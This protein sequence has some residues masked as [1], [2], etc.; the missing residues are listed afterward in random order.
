MAESAGKRTENITEVEKK[1]EDEKHQQNEGAEEEEGERRIEK[2]KEK[3]TKKTTEKSATPGATP[4][5]C[6]TCGIPLK[7]HKWPW[8][9]KCKQ[10]DLIQLDEGD[11]EE[12]EGAGEDEEEDES[13]GSSEA[14]TPDESSDPSSEEEMKKTK[15]KGKK[16]KTKK[17][18][19]R[20]KKK[21]KKREK[22]TSTPYKGNKTEG[23]VPALS[24]VAGNLD[25]TIV[26]IITE[27]LDKLG[28]KI[29][30]VD[31]KI[32]DDRA[33]RSRQS[34]RQYTN[35]EISYQVRDDIQC[36]NEVSDA[37][38]DLLDLGI[39]LKDTGVQHQRPLPGLRPVSDTSDVRH[40]R[41]HPG[42][43][44]ASI[45]KILSGEYC[46]L[47]SMLPAEIETLK[48]D[49]YETYIENGQLKC[50]IK[51]QKRDINSIICWI[52]AWAHYERIMGEY[53]GWPALKFLHEYKLRVLKWYKKY[54]WS[55]IYKWDVELRK[56][57]SL[58]SID[59]VSHDAALFAHHFDQTTYKPKKK[60]KCNYCNEETHKGPCNPFRGGPG[61]GTSTGQSRQTIGQYRYSAARPDSCYF[62]NNSQCLNQYCNRP[63]C[64][65]SC[66]GPMPSY[67]CRSSGRCSYTWYK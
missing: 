24:F 28:N 19:K 67:E 3:K 7:N 9:K 35:N 46:E 29:E 6:R 43:S 60:E 21:E 65:K 16:K 47:S 64:C 20:E 59:F 14:A 45:R 2:K 30:E 50:K 63:H 5:K 25:R 53:H 51:E 42:I 18:G 61:T 10:L 31:K 12:D 62:F 66:G 34:E 44:E 49:E 36:L 40:L 26:D 55:S 1:E 27:K 56:E 41:H 54:S 8:G 33:E 32:E 23:A 58:K 39:V 48:E 4:K 15:K 17:P 22:E 37:Q 11:S 52:E 38:Q 13:S 57:K